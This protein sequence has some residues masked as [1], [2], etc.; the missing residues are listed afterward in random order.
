MQCTYLSFLFF[1][2][3]RSC[4]NSVFALSVWCMECRLMWGKSNLK[5]FN[6]RQQHKKKKGYKYVLKALYLILLINYFLKVTL[7]MC[8]CNPQ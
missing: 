4:D 2:N 5:Q 3:L 8:T 6:I 7:H 1:I